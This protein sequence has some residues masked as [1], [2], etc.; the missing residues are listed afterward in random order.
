L[1]LLRLSRKASPCGESISEGF[2]IWL[3]ESIS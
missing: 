1:L 3:L 2:L